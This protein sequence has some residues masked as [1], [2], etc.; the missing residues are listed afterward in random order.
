MFIFQNQIWVKRESIYNVKEIP[1]NFQDNLGVI[2]NWLFAW[3]FLDDDMLEYIIEKKL[4]INEIIT[5]YALYD[6]KDYLLEDK[7]IKSV[8]KKIVP[9]DVREVEWHKHESQMKKYIQK[10]LFKFIY[11]LQDNIA[12]I[13]TDFRNKMLDGFLPVLWVE[14]TQLLLSD[15]E[16]FCQNNDSESNTYYNDLLNFWLKEHYDWHIAD[17]ILYQWNKYKDN[18]I[19]AIIYKKFWDKYNSKNDEHN[20][21]FDSLEKQFDNI[22]QHKKAEKKWA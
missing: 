9:L 21:L 20:K 11:P 18:I 7:S 8:Y 4:N 15:T 3:D 17:K 2:E 5:L 13:D 16:T 10:N 19:Y 1:K 14:D 22:I 6:S 12:H